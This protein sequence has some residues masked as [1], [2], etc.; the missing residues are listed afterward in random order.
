MRL[1]PCISP[2]TK[3]KSQGSKVLQ[4]RTKTMNFLEENIEETLPD[5][6][7]GNAF[8]FFK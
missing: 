2:R 6:G 5:I 7:I 4:V 8:F 3:I 1:D